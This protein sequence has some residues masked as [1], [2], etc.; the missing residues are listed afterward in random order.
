MSN[1]VY[2]VGI[3]DVD[4]MGEPDIVAQ[5]RTASMRPRSREAVSVFSSQ[6]GSRVLRMSRTVIS[7]TDR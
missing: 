4:G 6:I 3:I 1:P 2:M 5:A 7:E